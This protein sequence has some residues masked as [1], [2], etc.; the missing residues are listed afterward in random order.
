MRNLPAFDPL[1]D[2]KRRRDGL[3]EELEKLRRDLGR[4]ERENERIRVMQASGRTVTL[5]DEDAT[6]DLIRRY[7]MS[8]EEATQPVESQVLAKA[9]LDPLALLPFAGRPTPIV[10]NRDDGDEATV[11]SH[12]PVSMSA[13]EEL[14]FLQLFSPFNISAHLSMLPS[15]GDGRH[16]QHTI[17]L[18]SRH[19]PGLFHARIEVVTDPMK[20]RVLSLKV[21]AIDPAA[22]PE[23]EPFVQK[24]CAGKCNRSMQANCGIITW[25]M[26]EW[27][28]VA[29]HRA[30]FW[31]QLQR[32]LGS[33]T[34]LAAV[35]RKAR[36]RKHKR[37]RDEDGSTTGSGS[38]ITTAELFTLIGR[39]T[40]DIEVPSGEGGRG[41]A[42]RLSWK[43]DFDWTGEAQSKVS[44]LTSLPGKCKNTPRPLGFLSFKR[45]DSRTGHKADSKQVMGKLPSLFQSLVENGDEPTVAARK[46]V[47]LLVAED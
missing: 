47:S 44:A 3:Q 2:K 16:Q 12:H 41:A 22:R 5:G 34:S 46:L 19:V 40:L 18:T 9:A 36:S 30:L 13:E 1:S 4:A 28:R 38:T 31:S 42:L 23:L 14:P 7:L 33:K 10:L 21:P 37:G 6:L 45:V 11:R 35:A 32:E 15:E 24:V 17:N 43:I 27:L 26:A 29:E 25:A 39:Q 8:D 20:L